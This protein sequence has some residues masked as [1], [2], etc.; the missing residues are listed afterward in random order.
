MR[1]EQF[2]KFQLCTLQ[3]IS[4]RAQVNLLDVLDAAQVARQ[5]EGS[6]AATEVGFALADELDDDPR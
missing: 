6:I 3:S 5:V 1:K 4:K 2:R